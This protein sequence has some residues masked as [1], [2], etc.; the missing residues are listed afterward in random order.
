MGYSRSCL[1]HPFR[2]G[3]GDAAQSWR[4]CRVSPSAE[5]EAGAES[6]LPAGGHG[7][8]GPAASPHDPG[9]QCWGECVCEKEREALGGGVCA[10]VYVGVCVQ[11]WGCGVC[12]QVWGVRACVQMCVCRH[13]GGCMSAGVCR[14]VQVCVWLRE[15]APGNSSKPR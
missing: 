14:C 7:G 1:P 3:V 12:V 5:L 11:V 6:G 4:D 10:G 9:H 8:P 15:L 2:S 13:V